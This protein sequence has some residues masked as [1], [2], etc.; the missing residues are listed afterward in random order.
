M[1]AFQHIDN[2]AELHVFLG[3]E[4]QEMV[5]QV[6]SFSQEE[7]LVLILA[8]DDQ[9]NSFFTN[10]LGYLVQPTT[11]QMV[12]IGT[13]LGKVTAVMN[14][15]LQIE[16][17]IGCGNFFRVIDLIETGIVAEMADRTGGNRFYQEGI[18]VAILDDIS[19]LQIVSAG[20]SFGPERLAA[21]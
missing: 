7:T 11:E 19:Y 15:L 18:M 6:G 21:P 13:F 16:K 9:L 5:Q 17:E 2:L 20:L 14:D 10:L 12:G 1:S 3:K 8:L 4:D